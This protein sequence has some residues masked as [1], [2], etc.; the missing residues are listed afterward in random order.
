MRYVKQLFGAF[1]WWKLEPKTD[2]SL[3]TTALGSGKSRI[4]PALASDRSFAMVWT[5]GAPS[6]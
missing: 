6:R 2:T 1:E 4:C 3:V 5:T